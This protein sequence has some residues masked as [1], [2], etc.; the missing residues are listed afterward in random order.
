LCLYSITATG[1]IG[2]HTTTIEDYRPHV[3][4][5][6]VKKL[7]GDFSFTQK[8]EYPL[9]VE[10]K[11]DGKAGCADGG[12]C[13]QRCYGMLD[14][15]GI[16]LKDS[17]GIFYQLLDT[18]HIPYSIECDAWCYEYAGTNVIN[19]YKRFETVTVYSQPGIATHC[20]LVLELQDDICVPFI[21][22]NSI[23]QD[24]NE[25]FY[26]Q[27]GNITIDKTEFKKGILKAEFDLV[28]KNTLE[29]DKPIYWKGKLYSPILKQG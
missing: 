23:I 11:E 19:T 8:W 17:A 29:P 16:V 12:F 21:A 7:K 26:Y 18:T 6:W 1:Q 28:F 27:S 2:F 4:I 5:N 10:K 9:G 24:G 3:K 14:S 15:N 25:T 22:L 13:P 20:I